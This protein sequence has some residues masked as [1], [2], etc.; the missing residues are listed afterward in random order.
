M[1]LF[2]INLQD[3]IPRKKGEMKGEEKIERRK[4]RKRVKGRRETFF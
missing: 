2:A 4:Q 3:L 1:F